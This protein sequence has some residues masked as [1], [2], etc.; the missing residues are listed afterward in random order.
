MY[1][2]RRTLYISTLYIVHCKQYIVPRTMYSVCRMYYGVHCILYITHYTVHQ[3][4]CY[5]T[6]TQTYNVRITLYCISD[7]HCMSY[8]IR[9]TPYAVYCTSYSTIRTLY[10]VHYMSYCVYCTHFSVYV[11]TMYVTQ[12]T[13]YGYFCGTLYNSLRY[14]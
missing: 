11:H 12:S 9:H 5:Y 1:S 8:N 3:E 13:L 2:V 7:V 4:H 10:A 6:C 14:L